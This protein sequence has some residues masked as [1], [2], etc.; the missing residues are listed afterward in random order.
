MTRRLAATMTV[1]ALLVICGT[2]PAAGTG[3]AGLPVP[4]YD[5]GDARSAARGVLDRPEYQRPGPGLIQRVRNWIV[6][7]IER[8]LG[9][10]LERGRGELLAWAV[11]I[12]AVLVVIFLVYRFGRGV[13]PDARRR[14]E[15]VFERRRTPADWRAEAEA[16]ARAGRWREAVRFRY[17]ALVAELG[18]RG[19]VD[20]VP[21]RTAGEYRREVADSAPAVAPVFSQATDLF[22][23]SWYGNRP[24][25]EEQDTRLRELS[26][27]VLSGSA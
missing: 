2:S 15:P 16:H 21:G 5:V 12:G 20:D 9:A 13:T 7:Q 6:E 25:A 26:D 8:A 14:V 24:T 18:V 11:L 4:D 1:V 10:V 22:E 27:A 19:L 3:E 17:R 23:V